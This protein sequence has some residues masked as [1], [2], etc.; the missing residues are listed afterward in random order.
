MCKKSF[1]MKLRLRTQMIVL[2]FVLWPLSG[3]SVIWLSLKVTEWFMIFMLPLALF[4]N[5]AVSK[6]HCEH[7]GKPLS[8]NELT[9]IRKLFGVTL[10]WWTPFIP[11]K[12]SSCGKEYDRCARAAIDH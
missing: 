3:L 4:F 8:W 11:K 6:L 2:M 12:C 1:S 9:F 10:W 7:C 5:K